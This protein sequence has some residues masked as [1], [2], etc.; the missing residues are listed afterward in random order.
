MRRIKHRVSSALQPTASSDSRDV[1]GD[2]D[3][4]E[5]VIRSDDG[6]LGSNATALVLALVEAI[7]IYSA[8]YLS[9]A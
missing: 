3:V 5:V 2:D 6:D 8:I 7:F 4:E 9:Y 1:N